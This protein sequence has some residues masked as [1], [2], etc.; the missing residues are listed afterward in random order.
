ML[1]ASWPLQD[2][3][4]FLQIISWITLPVLL[5]AIVSTVLMHY[6][7]RR[8]K[9]LGRDAGDTSPLEIKANEEELNMLQAEL[10]R[11]DWVI[12]QLRNDVTTLEKNIQNMRLALQLKEEQ[13]SDM[14]HIL[15]ENR[16]SLQASQKPPSIAAE[17]S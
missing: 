7:Q 8:K 11:Q 2:F 15:D 5:V 6:Y 9:L 3:A 10:R 16:S 13:L 12:D 4:G 1:I 14:H 17:I